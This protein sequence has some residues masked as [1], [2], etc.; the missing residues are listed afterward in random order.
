MKTLSSSLTQNGLQRFERL[1]EKWSDIA[2]TSVGKETSIYLFACS[3]FIFNSA[4]KYQAI[5]QQL[6]TLRS[7]EDLTHVPEFVWHQTGFEQEAVFMSA[8]RQHRHHWF[9]L[10]AAR[11][12]LSLTDIV[13]TMRKV[14]DTA[15]FYFAQTRAWAIEH[16]KPRWGNA[17][18]ESDRQ[19]ELI[20]LGMGK[21]GGFELNFSS[22]IDLIFAYSEKGTTSGGRKS[23]DFQAYFTKVAQKIIHLLDTQT[24]D[25]RVFRVDMRLRPFG[26][27]G[28]LVSSFD[29]LEDYYQ[30]Q[31]RDWERYALLKAR[32]MVTQLVSTP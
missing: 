26:D 2:Y 16:L 1:S 6:L 19:I 11:D 22:D 8:L 13:D 15:D 3:E 23:E 28:P 32:P 10:I 4:F 21:L 18:G 30:E 14:S 5:A 31:G 27:S 17:N 7:Q 20:A 9:T 24:A 29:A 25:G 12:F